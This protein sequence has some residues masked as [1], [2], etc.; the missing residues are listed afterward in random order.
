L[1]RVGRRSGT[2]AEAREFAAERALRRWQQDEGGD[3][4]PAVLLQVPR[5]HAEDVQV[6]G[7]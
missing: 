6:P 3:V 7:V 5:G 4:L 2:A 1:P